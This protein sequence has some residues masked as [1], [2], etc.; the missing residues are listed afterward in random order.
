MKTNIS[1]LLNFKLTENFKKELRK[2]I[3]NGIKKVW[4]HNFDMKWKGHGQ[5]VY[6][7][8]IEVDAEKM[9]FKWETNDSESY[10]FWKGAQRS[11]SIDNFEKRRILSLFEQY[12]DEL[13]EQK[14]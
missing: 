3:P 5:Y 8:D 10:D 12:Q 14:V 4:L 6:V 7:L 2:L 1:S 11:I 13:W 9:S